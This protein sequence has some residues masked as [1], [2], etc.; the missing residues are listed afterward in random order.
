MSLK[1]F[2]P[3]GAAPKKKSFFTDDVV[4]RFRSGY[5]QKKGKKF[6]PAALSAWR[7]TT[8]DPDVASEVASLL[9]GGEPKE[10][11][12][13]GEDNLEVFTDAEEVEV[14]LDGP[15]ALRQRMVLWGRNGKM[16]RS[17]DGEVLDDGTPDPQAGQTL[18]ER[19][20]AA[21]EGTGAEPQIEIY[22]RLADNP[23]LGL[24]KFQTGSWSMASDLGYDGIEE[25]IAEVGG[26]VRATLSLVEVSFEAKN[27]PRAGQTVTYTKPVLKVLGEA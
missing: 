26:P 16:I 20:A 25:K 9:G 6:V 19:K 13:S 22:F 1:I 27:G 4:G 2:G 8:G 21:R 11:D 15:K 10:W 17:G 7:V 14:I 12:A 18:A 24:F 3:D 23:D 5:Q